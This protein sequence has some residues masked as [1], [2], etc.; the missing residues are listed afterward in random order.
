M[1]NDQMREHSAWRALVAA[2]LDAKA[3]TDDDCN[4]PTTDDSTPGRRLFQAIREWAD[5]VVAYRCKAGREG[6]RDR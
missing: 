6:C 4:A 2:L 3:V 1:T 5:D